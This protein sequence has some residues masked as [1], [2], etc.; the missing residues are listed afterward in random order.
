MSI[1]VIVLLLGVVAMVVGPVMLLQPSPQDRRQAEL[2]AQ[3][4][5]FGLVVSLETLPDQATDTGAP[6]RLPVYRLSAQ[7]AEARGQMQPWQLLRAA[8]W[9]ETHFL[10]DWRW[11]GKGRPKAGVL[12]IFERYLPELPKAVSALGSDSRGWYLVWT[13]KGGIAVLE[14]LAELLQAIKQASL[15]RVST[16]G[17]L[18]ARESGSG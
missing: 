3:A 5:R 10:G 14:R 11:Q 7:P 13:E 12:A 9:H 16:Q 8:Y 15:V 17:A 1:W 2:R 18:P 4:R 6:E